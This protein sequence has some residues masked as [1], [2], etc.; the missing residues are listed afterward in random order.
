LYR[1][2]GSRV[3]HA[4]RRFELGRVKS[5]QLSTLMSASSVAAQRLE[6]QSGSMHDLFIGAAMLIALAIVGLLA[7]RF[8]VDTRQPP[9]AWW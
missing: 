5:R 9:D 7:N 2:D 1:L 6:A 8:G 3:Q 4:H